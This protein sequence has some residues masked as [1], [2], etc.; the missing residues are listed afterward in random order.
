MPE[1]VRQIERL[2]EKL[3]GPRPELPKP[4]P[5][6][7]TPDT[8]QPGDPVLIGQNTF[9]EDASDIIGEVVEFQAR[10]GFMQADLVL[11]RYTRPRDGSEHVRP[12]AAAQLDRGDPESLL[13]RAVRHEEQAA[14]LRRM[15]DE[16]SR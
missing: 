8:Y 7:D 13:A 14:K 15:A 12:F 10:A 3:P 1:L 4:R 11:V 9:H 2:V 6:P 5:S 16:V